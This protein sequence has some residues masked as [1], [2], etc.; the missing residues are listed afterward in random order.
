MVHR[1][2]V[3]VSEKFAKM[4]QWKLLKFEVKNC[5]LRFFAD[6]SD[7]FLASTVQTNFESNIFVIDCN[8]TRTQNHLAL[9]KQTQQFSQTG[10]QPFGQLV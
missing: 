9:E 2:F 7:S 4:H 3:P 8:R 6:G 5:S 10:T 1:V